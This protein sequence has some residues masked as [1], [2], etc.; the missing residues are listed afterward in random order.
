MQEHISVITRL[1]NCF[2][3]LNCITLQC[4]LLFLR[5]DQTISTLIKIERIVYTVQRVHLLLNNVHNTR[6]ICRITL[7]DDNME[8]IDSP[9]DTSVNKREHWRKSEYL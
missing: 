1:L 3:N 2:L 5:C 6:H 4:E 8:Q 7:A 9:H